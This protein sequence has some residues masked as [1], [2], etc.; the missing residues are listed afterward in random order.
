MLD[1]NM[2]RGHIRLMK[3]D[4]YLEANGLTQE[5]FALQIKASQSQVSR[6]LGDKP[7]ASLGLLARVKKATGGAVTA[8]DFLVCRAKPEDGDADAPDC[9]SERV[10]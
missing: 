8:D 2:H 10:A 6:L 1:K 4:A 7:S 5:A 9:D 3:L